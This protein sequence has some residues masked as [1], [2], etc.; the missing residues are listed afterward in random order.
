MALP[1]FPAP[2][3]QTLSPN[4]LQELIVSAQAR[5]QT[6]F[7]ER[8]DAVRA[9]FERTL[10][11]NQLTLDQVFPELRKGKRGPRRGT[12]VPPKYR[13]PNRL[14][15]VWSG[16]GKTPVWLRELIQQGRARDEFLIASN[17]ESNAPR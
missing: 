4:Q 13:N 8:V 17:G 12:I 10:T 14:E 5:S 1:S 9:Q 2:D 7:Q 6:L 15:Q 16:R 3:L 11:E